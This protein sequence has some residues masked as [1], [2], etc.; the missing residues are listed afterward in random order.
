MGFPQRIFNANDFNNMESGQIKADRT[1]CYALFLFRKVSK[2]LLDKLLY[3]FFKF[4]VSFFMTNLQNNRNRN[5]RVDEAEYFYCHRIRAW[6]ENDLVHCN[7]RLQH[8][9][10]M[11]LKV[12]CE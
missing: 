10:S 5:W 2:Q 12:D 7:H 9:R 1:A 11:S 4:I 3:I 8:V 6:V